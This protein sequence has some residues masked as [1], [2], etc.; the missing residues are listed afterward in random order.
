MDIINYI[1]KY[2]D[3][4]FKDKPFN[5]V[6]N[7]ILATLS[8]IDFD[9]IVEMNSF[10][11]ITLH[12]AAKQYFTKYNK[13]ELA[14]N[15][16]GVQAA[17]KIFREMKNT[18]R[19]QD[20]P[21]YNY[22]YKC[23]E[24]KQFSA[25]FIDL[26]DETTYISYEGTD[27]LISGWRE[28]FEMSYK[29][30]VPAQ[31]EAIKYINTHI[32]IFTKRR[33]IVGGHSKGGNLALVSAMYANPLIRK[34]IIKVYSNDGPGLKKHQMESR[35]FR[36]VAPKYKLIISN[37]AVIGLLLRHPDNYLV[38]HSNK[39]G[40]LAH[41]VLYWEVTSNRFLRTK[42]SSYSINL[43]EI[44]TKWLDEYD[45]KAREEFVTDLFSVFDRA[46][47]DSLLDLKGTGITN[48]LSILKETKNINPESRKM[49][50]AFTKF[51]IDYIK[52]DALSHIKFLN[53][54]NK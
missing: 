19:Y 43:D 48:I 51:I 25:L 22:V 12:A 37:Y 11:K 13:K 20:L 46:N 42:L 45:D 2:G 26:D 9:G 54:D 24:S 23:D 34:K 4:T 7:V 5:E 30:P 10:S 1:K 50:H 44:I 47:I 21:L 27:E 29:F 32:N 39:S 8:Y 40:L 15:I 3:K 38:V 18:E 28:D 17:I 41:N 31:R 35:Q 36:Y 33:F 49:I 16:M 53:D 14:Y 6:D 52:R